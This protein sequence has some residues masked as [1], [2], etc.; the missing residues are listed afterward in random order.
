MSTM[1]RCSRARLGRRQ[2]ATASLLV[3]L[4]IGIG[5]ALPAHASVAELAKARPSGAAWPERTLLREQLPLNQAV[6]GGFLFAMVS[7][8][9]TPERGPY[10]LVR[11]TLATRAVRKGSLFRLPDV[12]VASGRLWITGSEHGLPRAIEV[13]P[14]SLRAIRAIRFSHGYGAYPF[15]DVAQG[16][17]G[18]VWLGSDRTLL[19][20]SPANGKAL[21]ETSVPT[22]FVVADLAT[23]PNTT[24]LYVSLAGTVKGG[25]AGGG[26]IE[27]D[28]F[29]GRQ[30]ATASSTL[31]S[32]SV[33]GSTLTAVPGG[34]WASFRTGMLGLTLRFRQSDLAQI[35]PP[36]AKIALTPANGLFHWPM[37][38][39]TLYGGGSLWLT[40]ES[41]VRAC[42]DPSTGKVRARQHIPPQEVLDLLAVD[43]AGRH[44]LAL[45]N[46]TAVIEITPP[47][48]CW[49]GS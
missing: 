38:A 34:V 22:G 43:P 21:V 19:R 28:A 46:A 42:L 31:L 48:Q 2:L 40:N 12:A 6:S 33:A 35:A 13:D 39:S 45:D 30:L 25:M 16:P 7:L 24:H 3:G 44:L 41:G 29:S 8:T 10:R 14:K 26:L 15:V 27:D 49:R 32:G 47:A 1:K 17:A 18:S 23:D 4:V 20:V 11:T 9:N 36:G 5:G 37:S